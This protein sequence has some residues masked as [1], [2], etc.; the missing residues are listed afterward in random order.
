[1]SAYLPVDLQGVYFQ[2]LEVTAPQKV[3]G[4]RA[5]EPRSKVQIFTNSF[6]TLMIWLPWIEPMSKGSSMVR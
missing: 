2:M 5:R 1:M 3:L 6:R 4:V